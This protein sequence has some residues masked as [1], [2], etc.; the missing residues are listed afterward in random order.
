MSLEPSTNVIYVISLA[1]GDD[2]ESTF[3]LTVAFTCIM[4]NNAN[5]NVISLIISNDECD[6]YYVCNDKCSYI[7]TT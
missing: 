1:C 4:S 2:D 6:Y 7:D 3:I 5:T